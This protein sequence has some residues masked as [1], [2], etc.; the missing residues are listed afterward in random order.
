[1]LSSHTHCPELRHAPLHHGFHNIFCVQNMSNVKAII[2][3]VFYWAQSIW[4]THNMYAKCKSIHFICKKKRIGTSHLNLGAHI[5]PLLSAW[6]SKDKPS[7]LKHACLPASFSHHNQKW[8]WMRRGDPIILVNREQ[9]TSAPSRQHESLE[10]GTPQNASLPHPWSTCGQ[11][12]ATPAGLPTAVPGTDQTILLKTSLKD[13][14]LA[15]RRHYSLLHPPYPKGQNKGLINFHLKC[16]SQLNTF[17]TGNH[18]LLLRR[19]WPGR[20]LS[21]RTLGERPASRIGSPERPALA[22]E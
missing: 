2:I 13:S 16:V 20:P 15:S 19:K 12:R 14:I 17:F 21:L 7:S 1:M 8:V 10:Q 3:V 4:R 18:Q 9:D 5:R 22:P 11:L 6:E